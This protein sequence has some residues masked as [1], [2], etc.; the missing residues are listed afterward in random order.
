TPRQD[1]TYM[2]DANDIKWRMRLFLGGGVTCI[3]I[4]LA[5][6]QIKG[7]AVFYYLE[8]FALHDDGRYLLASASTL[9]CLNTLRAVFLYIGWFNLGESLSY[10]SHRWKSLSWIIP[11]VAIPCSYVLLS[12]M[13]D[14][15][16][17]HFG[18]PALFSIVTVIV[19]QLTT[20]E[21]KGWISRLL[22]IA[23]MVFA[24][25]WLD[26]AP[27]LSHWGFGGGELSSAVKDFAILEEWD[28]VLDGLSFG[29]FFSTGV[30]GM[31]A[32][33][34]LAASSQRNAHL[35]KIRERELEISALREEAISIRSH[36]EVQQLVHDLARPLTTILGLA[37]VL[38][39][40]LAPGDL[41]RYAETVSRAGANMNQMI[42]ELLREDARQDVMVSTLFEYVLSQISAFEWRHSVTVSADQNALEKPIRIN[43]IRLS[44]ALVNLLDNANLAMRE[45]EVKE[46]RLSA[47]I[48]GDELLL[49][50]TDNGSGFSANYSPNSRGHSEWGSTGIG[51]AFVEEVAKNHGGC[52]AI[53][54]RP[55]GG[56]VVTLH[57]PL[58]EKDK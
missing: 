24:F 44:R 6:L 54:N 53:A 51:L 41:R 17:L 42:N 5:T 11:L 35:K 32:A 12:K 29:M 22:I 34:L 39:E 33:A 1:F 13:Q 9:V 8:R 26:L 7:S 18:T 36:Q 50:V 49:S 10:L 58:V 52:L 40:R 30:G 15:L 57:L 16:L 31:A 47:T 25:Q 43:L 27:T 55:A 28:W 3:A 21:I 46:I 56:A 14:G 48:D 4:W 45:A 37:D 19:M 23:L 2:S 38:A 20:R